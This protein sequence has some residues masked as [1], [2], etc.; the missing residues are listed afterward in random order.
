MA[1]NLLPKDGTAILFTDIFEPLSADR[2]Y[3]NLLERIGW[4]E[5]NAILFGRA[6]KVP[7]LVAWYGNKPYKYSGIIHNPQ[8]WT[9][10]LLEIKAL[11]ETLAG[12]G[13]NSVLLNLYRDGQ[14]SMGWHADDERE[15]GEKPIIASVSLGATRKFQMRHK[16]DKALRIE[17]PLPHGSCLVMGGAMQHNWQHQ[18]P[19]T[20]RP[21]GQRINLT[22][23]TIVD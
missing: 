10:D 22:F 11:V 2:L 23:R 16:A 12:T 17:T 1:C 4:Q 21:V 8:D 3:L 14:D 18:I 7:R 5:E 6:I 15:L 20:A 13:F 9:P 19:K